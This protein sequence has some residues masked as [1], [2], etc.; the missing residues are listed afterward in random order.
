MPPPSDVELD[1]DDVA[2]G[3]H[4]LL[5]LGAQLALGARLRQAAQGQQFLVAE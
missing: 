2:V 3:D 1:V 5:A 4:V